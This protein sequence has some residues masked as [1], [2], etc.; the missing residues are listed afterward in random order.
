SCQFCLLL[1][2]F[3]SFFRL[4]RGFNDAVNGFPDDGWSL[5][6][7]DGAEVLLDCPLRISIVN[8]GWVPR[9]W[10]DKK[11]KD[12]QI[13]DE[14]SESPEVVKPYE[15]GSWWKFWSNKPK[16]SPEFEKPRM[17]PVRVVGV[18]RGSE[19]P[20]IFVPANEPN[21]GQWFYVDVPMIARACGLPENT[22]YI[23]D[24][25]EDQSYTV[26]LTYIFSDKSRKNCAVI[27]LVTFVSFLCFLFSMCHA[28][29]RPILYDGKME[30]QIRSSGV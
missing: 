3:V 29:L 15:K 11:V 8:R 27:F 13:L 26:V 5:M 18:I 1:V 24:I 23:E 9:G 12:L 2:T 22:I 14:A 28:I 30:F 7:S 6:S 10:H 16:S 17:P 4:S 19:K 25:N 20:S 21:S